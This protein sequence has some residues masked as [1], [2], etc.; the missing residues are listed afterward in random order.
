MFTASSIGRFGFFLLVLGF[1]ITSGHSLTVAQDDFGNHVGEGGPGGFP[2]QQPPLRKWQI[3]KEIE[4]LRRPHT[5]SSAVIQDRVGAD[6]LAPVVLKPTT[7]D[8]VLL[9]KLTR[10]RNFDF[11]GTPLAEFATQLSTDLDINVLVDSRA[12]ENEGIDVG[13]NVSFRAN[14]VSYLYVLKHCLKPLG[15]THTVEGNALRITSE[16]KAE[17]S[18]VTRVYPVYDLIR[19]N[20]ESGGSDDP[21]YL[22]NLIHSTIAPNS[23]DAVGGPATMPYYKGMLTISQTRETHRQIEQLL[24]ALRHFP[25]TES[26]DPRADS[27]DVVGL[28]ETDQRRKIA[29]SMQRPAT[30]DLDDVPLSEAVEALLEDTNV[31]FVFDRMALEENSIDL[32]DQVS[33]S[34]VDVPTGNALDVMLEALELTW[35]IDS[36]SIVITSTSVAEETLTTSVYGVEGLV[37]DGALHDEADDLIQ[38]IVSVCAPSSWDEVGGPASIEFFSQ[39]NVLVVSNTGPVHREVASQLKMLLAGRKGNNTT[40]REVSL[41]SAIEVQVFELSDEFAARDTG[42]SLIRLLEQM[43]AGS[44][45]EINGKRTNFYVRAVGNTLVISHRR[46][47]LKSLSSILEKL[48]GVKGPWLHET[49][50]LGGGMMGGGGGMMGGG[51][52]MMGGGGGMF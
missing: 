12:L 44:D 47:A 42:E 40:P 19:V 7:D 3:T 22:V 30:I 26:G 4:R 18:L 41:P 39:R 15:A 2:R 35:R 8:A 46:D 1:S 23:W 10:K 5:Q 11:N 37:D 31:Q 33:L 45:N 49:G 21:A 48:R 6:E 28:G 16:A 38:N 50:G 25:I 32:S 27:V 9:K 17:E 29:R 34:L 52:G 36:E 14:E 51:G 20:Q 13:D 24:K 43:L